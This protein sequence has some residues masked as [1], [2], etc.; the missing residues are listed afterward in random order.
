MSVTDLPTRSAAHQAEHDDAPLRDRWQP[1]RAGIINVWRYYDETFTF[2]RGRL[3]L[4]GQN[5]TGKSK[6][7]ELLL[8]FLFDASLRPNRLSTFGGSERTMHWNLMGEG[9]TGKT[10]VGYVWMEF[11]RPADDGGTRWFTCGAR[12]QA[13]THTGSAHA[14]YFT[15]TR[16]VARPDGVLLVN[17]AGQPLTRSALA[18]ALDGH[19]EVHASPDAH[20]TAVRRALFAGMGE[21]RYEAL[22]TALLQL[23]QPKLS[24]RLD[25]SL[26]STLLSR[27]LPPLGEGEISE[28]AEGFERLDRQR[29]HLTRLDEEVAAAS[30]VAAQQRGYAQ[31]VLRAHAATLISA[32]TDLDNLTRVARESTEQ[33]EQAV[34]AQETTAQQRG[35]HERR[36]HELEAGIEGLIGSDAYKQGQELDKLRRRTENARQNARR[37]RLAADGKQGLADEDRQRAEAAAEQV[38][39][40]A[41]HVQDASQ[42]TRR[43]ARTAG[44][45]SV[46]REAEAMV[47]ADS[48]DAE[49]AAG[50]AGA[51]SASGQDRMRPARQLL[52]GALRARQGQIAEV[53]AAVERHERTVGERTAAEA[54]LEQARDGLAKASA[55]REETARAH[56]DALS[57]QEVLLRDWAAGCVELRIEDAEELASRAAVEADV[58]AVV[59]SA[60]RTADRDITESRTRVEAAREIAHTERTTLTDAVDALGREADLPPAVP[61]TRT[62]DRSVMIGAPL[63]RLVA[64]HDYVPVAVQASVEAALEASGLLDAWVSPYGG[65]ALPG[66]DTLA[67]A[68]WAVPAP[69]P[70]LLEV[71]RPE[72]GVLVPADVLSRLLGGIAYGSRLPAEHMAAVGADGSWRLASTTGTWSKPEPAH[73]GALAR[74]RA[75]RARITELTARLEEV[76]DSIAGLD[77]ELRELRDRRARL[78]ADLAARPH[79]R[80]LDAKRRAWDRAEEGVGVRDDAVRGAVGRLAERESDVATSLRTLSRLAA[81]HA[82]PTGRE[83]LKDLAIAVD[84]FRDTADAWT[85]AHLLRGVAAERAQTAGAHAA[86]SLDTAQEHAAGAEAA[87]EEA[88]A[89]AAT[90]EA[91]E[92]TVGEDFRAIAARIGGLRT[93][94]DLSRAGIRAKDAELLQ[95]AQIIGSLNEKTAQDVGKRDHAVGA[96]DEAARRFRH[97]CLLGLPEDAGLPVQLTAQDGTRATLEAA[98]EVAAKWASIPYGA[99]NLGDAVNRLS[100]AVHLARQFLGRR[101]DL[102]LES[103]EDVQVFSAS[104]DGVRIGAAGLLTTLTA[105]RDSSRDDITAAERK[106]FDQ[107]LTGDTRRHL[108]SRIRQANELVDRMNGHL[109][110]V[111]T[112]SK[113]AVQL[114][115]QIHPDLPP[116]TRTAR[117]LLLKDP[118]RITEADREALH[119]FFRNRIEEAKAK[120][121]AARWEEQLAEVLDYTAWHQFVVRLD[122][123]NG[124]GWQLLTKKLHGALSGGEKAIALHLPL[125]AAVASHYEAVPD[126]PRPILLDEVFVGVDTTNRGQV[127]ALLSALD[128][129]LVLTSDHEWCTYRELPGIAV[130][131]LITGADDGDDAVTS[132]RF[133]WDGAGLEPAEP[134]EAEEHLA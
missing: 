70:S 25:P 32:T 96:R 100:E 122:R 39:A 55:R 40:A 117:E 67:D 28:L 84:A 41:A 98:R 107:T 60:V 19:G 4:R 14:D 112:A 130:H 121:K 44:L 35:D 131:Q 77:A 57:A 9:A 89:L 83:L 21:Q 49:G 47:G 101:A 64:F 103:D 104:M 127:F 82:L 29:E 75:R 92:S 76:N 116:G 118:A 74:E 62:T 97:L 38:R 23:R 3:L 85:E 126:A 17:E 113:V 81:E 12:L 125:F 91:V 128:L 26:L 134:A 88:L 73:I 45:E 48:P 132:A 115:W 109:Q 11:S 78:D 34:Q 65:V 8:P 16:R 61:L 53:A 24:E 63:W 108:A 86:L 5:G 58:M 106:L 71:L 94:L 50:A 22:I 20:R 102:D 79:H 110:R 123:A 10:R 80:D 43:A 90:L 120:N 52:R 33:R 66:H 68:A 69:G 95:L 59:E 54:T 124:A 56:E 15:T 119:V 93:E 37:L 30:T 114:V 133:I 31:R 87:G 111:R 1:S 36:A 13:S 99:R 42:D 72:A 27:A 105:E 6:A 129:D 51:S 7:L 2:H 18:D 46:Y